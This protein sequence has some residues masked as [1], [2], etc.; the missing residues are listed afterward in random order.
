MHRAFDA[1]RAIAG[2]MDGTLLQAADRL[3][4]SCT[5]FTFIACSRLIVCYRIQWQGQLHMPC[6]RLTDMERV[7]LRYTAST[8]KIAKFLQA[9]KSGSMPRRGSSCWST[10][11][12][13]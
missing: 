3:A 8:C 12:G 4:S 7:A 2:L 13:S 11:A 1:A 6:F 5:L 10:S 9:L